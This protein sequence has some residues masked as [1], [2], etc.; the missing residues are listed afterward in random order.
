MISYVDQ[1]IWKRNLGA[2]S[3]QLLRIFRLRSEQDRLQQM[4]E[5][6]KASLKDR[7][8]ETEK[9]YIR[10]SEETT[11]FERR[12]SEKVIFS[13]KCYI[14]YVIYLLL[15]CLLELKGTTN[16]SNKLHKSALIEREIFFKSSSFSKSKNSN[17]NQSFKFKFKSSLA[18]KANRLKWKN[19]LDSKT[20]KQNCKHNI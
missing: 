13:L 17:S 4:I 15:V 1:K 16:L 12:Y 5:S 7:E 9:A 6:L 10:L 19:K 20:V 18:L 8:T 2:L 3:W 14:L 11:A